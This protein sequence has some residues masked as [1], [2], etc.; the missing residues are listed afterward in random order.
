MNIMRQAACLVVHPITV[1]NFAALFN[2][3]PTGRASDSMMVPAMNFHLSRLCLYAL[4]LIGPTG[5][6]LLGI[7]CPSVTVVVLLLSNLSC[8]VSVLNLDLCV[9]YFGAL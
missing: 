9:C 1:G 4:S 3:T 6:Q 5:V 8:F 7:C 2:C